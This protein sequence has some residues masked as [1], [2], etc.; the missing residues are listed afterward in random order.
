MLRIKFTSKTPKAVSHVPAERSRNL[1][2]CK[3]QPTSSVKLT[4]T[5]GRN[6]PH[7]RRQR[8]KS[9]SSKPAYQWLVRSRSS[10]IRVVES[11]GITPANYPSGTPEAKSSA[12]V[13]LTRILQL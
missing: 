2:E 1:W 8:T 6:K 9:G 11:H 5:F 3:S 10:F 13:A 12:S 7:V 4:L